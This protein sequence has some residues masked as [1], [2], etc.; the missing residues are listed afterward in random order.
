MGHA[1]TELERDQA[2]LASAESEGC[3]A[4]RTW[5][6]PFSTVVVGRA[7]NIEDEVRTAFCRAHDI[8]VVRRSS[9]GRSVLVGPGTLQYSFA[10][11]YSLAPELASIGGA[12]RFCNALL[13]GA[14]ER[15][16]E[17]EQDESGDLVLDG[18]KVAGLALRRRRNA[19]LLHGTIL[20]DANVELIA[21]ALRRPVREPTYRDGR[22]HLEFLANLGP[23]DAADLE[24]TVG[25]GLARF[26]PA[27]A[28]SRLG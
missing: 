11:P 25:E 26:A 14:L 19:M 24:R 18:R 15:G 3:H 21:S 6:T 2:M 22:G 9:G 28:A 10:L 8:A 23:V 17:L 27:R 20:I 16:D 5:T 1:A 12:K 4:F 13:L 7:V